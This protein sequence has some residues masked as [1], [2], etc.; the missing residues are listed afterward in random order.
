MKRPILTCLCAISLWFGL[1]SCREVTLLERSY[2]RLT[3]NNFSTPLRS[4]LPNREKYPSSLT[5]R[6]SGTISQ[7]VF[8][9]VYYLDAGKPTYPALQDTLAAST[10]TDWQIRQDFYSREEIELQVTGAPGTTGSLALEWYC[11]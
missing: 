9:S 8:L 2:Q 10:Y 3:I 5:L 6:A 11:Q 1:I 4:R 7:P